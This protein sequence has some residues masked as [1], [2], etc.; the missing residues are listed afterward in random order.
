M[1]D[2]PLENS[3]S[4]A[5][6]LAP[7]A[8]LRD[9]V[10]LG[11]PRITLLVLVTTAV[12]AWLAPTALHPL[13]MALFL[14]ATAMLVA[15]ANTLNCWYERDVDA[16]MHRTRNRPLPAGRL[17]PVVALAFG[18][19][20]GAGALALL[21]ATTNPLTTALGALALGSYVL[22]YTPMK[23]T[24]P[25]AV[26]VGAVPGALPPLLGWT[27]ASGSFGGPG[28]LLFGIL[29]FWQLPHFLAI[30]LYLEDDYRRGGL[31]VFSVVHGDGVARRHLFAYTLLLVGVSFAALPLGLGGSLYLAAAAV[32]GAGFI[33]IAA[34]GL[35]PAV[36]AGWARAVFAY[37]LVYLPALITILVID[38]A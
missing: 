35:G 22:V 10:E 6:V 17:E 21:A 18:A 26:V 14:A 30:S 1:H 29:F 38:A 16:R 8:R 19:A 27:A 2:I 31:R 32:L 33:G 13:R 24:S 23:R 25:W 12:G 15:S 11:K 4:G 3:R 5:V 36:G 7:R 9:L 28:W 20:L 34:R 37:S